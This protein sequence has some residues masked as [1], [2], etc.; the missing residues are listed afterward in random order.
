LRGQ[1]YGLEYMGARQIVTVETAAGHLKVRV[2]ADERL[3]VGHTVGLRP[4]PARAILF[5][6]ATE[7]ALAMGDA[8][9]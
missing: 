4:D 7:R 5:D 9:G 8:D 6:A 2:A 3:R 1:V